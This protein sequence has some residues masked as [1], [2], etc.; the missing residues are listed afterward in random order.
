[1]NYMHLKTLS[2]STK[3]TKWEYFII[4]PHTDLTVPAGVLF[5]WGLIRV[6]LAI[7]AVLLVSLKLPFNLV[8]FSSSTSTYTLFTTSSVGE[9]RGSLWARWES[10]LNFISTFVNLMLK[11]LCF[12]GLFEN[13][14]MLNTCF[15][16]KN[17][18]T[19]QVVINEHFWSVTRPPLLLTQCGG[20]CGCWCSHLPT[21]SQMQLV[22]RE[23]VYDVLSDVG[24]RTS[25]LSM[26]KWT[27]IPASPEKMSPES[28]NH[29]F[30][31]KLMSFGLVPAPSPSVSISETSCPRS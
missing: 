15:W 27:V 9:P 11:T 28:S 7:K 24:A 18:K 17:T 6:M 10:A 2:T 5:W 1:M 29:Q 4:W 13:D 22:F 20:D 12:I 31:P 14:G 25:Q 23:L 16:S 19:K 3:S 30:L 8:P 21:G 26:R